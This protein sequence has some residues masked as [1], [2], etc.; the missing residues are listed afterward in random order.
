VLDLGERERALAIMRQIEELQREDGSIPAWPDCEWVCSSG[1][2]QYALIWLKL[3]SGTAGP[4]GVRLAVRPPGNGRGDSWAAM[5][6][7]RPIFPRRKS[8]GAAKYFLDAFLY[9][10]DLED[11]QGRQ[12]PRLGWNLLS[13]LFGDEG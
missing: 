1:V 3:G 6:S 12:I 5:A 13:V 8:V 11:P 7:R 2:A 4:T 10:V 9:L